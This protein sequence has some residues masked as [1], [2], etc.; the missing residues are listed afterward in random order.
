MSARWGLLSA[1]LTGVLLAGCGSTTSPTR[2]E[3]AVR[4]CLRSEHVGATPRSAPA[5]TLLGQ[6]GQGR[7]GLLVIAQDQASIWLYPSAR[8]ARAAYRRA[9]TVFPLLRSGNAIVLF[10][11]SQQPTV[12]EQHRLARCA[13]GAG[14]PPV[15]SPLIITAADE[16]SGRAV[17]VRS[18]CL[19]CHV[20]GNEGSPGPGPNLSRV[21]S[22]LSP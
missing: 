8:A 7:I 17:M 19:A 13:F 5:K 21:G 15:A 6:G 18:G 3:A 10:A 4:S 22:K 16:R 1:I 9:E 2:G 20:I 11:G 12:A 14:A